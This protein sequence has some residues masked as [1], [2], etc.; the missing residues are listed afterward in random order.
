MR[1]SKTFDVNLFE[2]MFNLNS[3]NK[4]GANTIA[5]FT[6]ILYK[7]EDPRKEI[8]LSDYQLARELGLSRQTVITAKNKLKLLGLLDYNRNRGFPNRFILN[9]NPMPKV[10]PNTY[11]IIDKPID[12]LKTIVESEINTNSSFSKYPNLKQFMDFA[13]TLK[14]YSEKLDDLL[15]QKFQKWKEA[16]WKNSLGR[17]I[18]NWQST[19][20]KNINTL[21]VSHYNKGSSLINLP[22]IK[23]PKLD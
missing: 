16:D 15:I 1:N 6:F 5:V 10:T 20:E 7:C 2:K 21:D 3:K 22:I 23:R 17:P 13:K 4:I 9:G 18:L 19:L 11:E 8:V 12:E 14:D